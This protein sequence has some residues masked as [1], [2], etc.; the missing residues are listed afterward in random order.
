MCVV[1]SETEDASHLADADIDV[2][3]V[4][5]Q[6]AGDGARAEKLTIRIQRECPAGLNI[7]TGK[8]ELTAA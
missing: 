1:A 7:S 6:I 3:A 5:R 8:P 2:T 4:V